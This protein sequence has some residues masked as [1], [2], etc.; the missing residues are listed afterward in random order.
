MSVMTTFASDSRVL[1]NRVP[2]APFV[3]DVEIVFSVDVRTRVAAFAFIKC[4]KA[5][6]DESSPATRG[7]PSQ[8][9]LLFLIILNKDFLKLA[10]A[11]S[12]LVI[13]ENFFFFLTL[14]P[15]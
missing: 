9:F 3:P 1:H 2:P 12:L 7:L 13:R 4:E 6:S 8:L 15:L 11:I 14:S 10:D 5:T